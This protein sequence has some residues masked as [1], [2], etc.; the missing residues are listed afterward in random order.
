[1]EADREAEAQKEKL[2]ACRIA[3]EKGMPIDELQKYLDIMKGL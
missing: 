1:M 2:V 3:L